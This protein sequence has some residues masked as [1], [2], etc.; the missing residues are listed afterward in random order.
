MVLSGKVSF[1]VSLG[2]VDIS[3]FSSILPVAIVLYLPIDTLLGKNFL[4]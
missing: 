2:P 1:C 3:E 4:P